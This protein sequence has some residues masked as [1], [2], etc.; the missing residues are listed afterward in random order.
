MLR[1]SPPWQAVLCIIYFVS[2]LSF[3]YLGSA[4]SARLGAD[5]MPCYIF[6]AAE[7]YELNLVIALAGRIHWTAVVELLTFDIVENA[8]HI[9]S[10][11]RKDLKGRES[12]ENAERR[13]LYILA[14]LLLR[15][16]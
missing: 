9:W 8:Y 13:K 10:L 6:L 1:V 15:E 4:L 7:G 14:A 5:A 11:Y 16:F 3:E 2:K 12:D